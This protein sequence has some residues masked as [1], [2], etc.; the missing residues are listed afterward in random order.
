MGL[1]VP[2]DQRMSVHGVSVPL[3]PPGANGRYLV[4]FQANLLTDDS[5]NA[6]TSPDTGYFDLFSL[7][8]SSAAYYNLRLTD[9]IASGPG[10]ALG[11]TF[12]GTRRNSG[13][14]STGPIDVSLRMSG[15][16]TSFLNAVLDTRAPPDADRL[17]PSSG[18]FKVLDITPE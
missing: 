14:A 13:G 16:N 9:P 5:Y 8:V 1:T 12:G 4:R 7:S 17:Y 6:R 15:G 3:R 10:L 18:T 2:G 11:F